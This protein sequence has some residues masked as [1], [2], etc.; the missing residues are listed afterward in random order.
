M[1]EQK[2]EPDNNNGP[3]RNQQHDDIVGEE[4]FGGVKI[5]DRIRLDSTND[6][7]TKLKRGD[8][9]TVVEFWTDDL[10]GSDGRYIWRMRVKWDTGSNLSLLHNVDKFTKIDMNEQEKEDHLEIDERELQKGR[11][12]AAPRS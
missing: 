10:K 7:F 11:D 9:G 5:G 12:E 1:N 4:F 2:E 3:Y 6:P 8:I